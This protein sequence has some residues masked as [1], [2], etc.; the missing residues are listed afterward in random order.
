MC[1]A[2]CERPQAG[3]PCMEATVADRNQEGSERQEPRAS[4]GKSDWQEKSESSAVT[5][6]GRD[7]SAEEPQDDRGEGTN[8]AGPD[9]GSRQADGR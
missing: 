5:N 8:R 4:A 9:V 1:V 6:A 2:P 7:R 3:H